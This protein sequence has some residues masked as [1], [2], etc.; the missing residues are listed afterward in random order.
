MADFLLYVFKLNVLA[1][2]LIVLVFW[3]VQVSEQKIFCLVEKLDL[4]GGVAGLAGSGS[5]TGLLECDPHS[6][7]AAG[8]GRTGSGSQGRSSGAG[9]GSG[10]G[11]SS[12]GKQSRCFR[13][14]GSSGKYFTVPGTGNTNA[15]GISDAG[16]G[17]AGGCGFVW[18]V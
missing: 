8:D 17:M 10:R 13:K 7:T 16:S 2:L 5:D 4:A 12:D 9:T 11:D 14:H 15:I 18:F 1:A 6:D 3:C